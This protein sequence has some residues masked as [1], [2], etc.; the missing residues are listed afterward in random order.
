MRQLHQRAYEHRGDVINNWQRKFKFDSKIT[1][2]QLQYLVSFKGIILKKLYLPLI[3]K[4]MYR[5][6]YFCFVIM[7]GY[8][9]SMGILL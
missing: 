8:H 9:D 3:M 6:F 1:L 7:L 4:L 2:G 5:N